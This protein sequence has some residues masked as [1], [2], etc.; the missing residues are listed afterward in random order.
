MPQQP[1]QQQYTQPQQQQQPQ[2]GGGQAPDVGQFF[3]GAAAGQMA[4]MGMQYGQAMFQQHGQQAQQM[5]EKYGLGSDT[6][7]AYFNV[8]GAYVLARFKVLLFPFQKSKDWRRR[9]TGQQQVQYGQQGYG[10]QTA[11]QQPMGQ[12]QYCSPREDEN[13]PDL[14]IPF[15]AFVTYILVAGF[16][17]GVEAKDKTKF[18]PEM[19]GR[20]SSFGC[21]FWIL[22]ILVVK[23]G[24]YILHNV[25]IAMWDATAY[26]GYKYVGVTLSLLAYL[27]LGQMAYYSTVLYTGCACGWMIKKSYGELLHTPGGGNLHQDGQDVEGKNLILWVLMGIQ[28]LVVFFLSAYV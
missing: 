2:Y 11:P 21:V 14:Y 27:F 15:M 9:T 28:V 24:V 5:A 18:S 26:A 13:A 16:C 20:T 4:N 3:E 25:P 10:Q 22:E 6:L 12:A 7:R 23:F 17:M 1:Q 19:L 8:D